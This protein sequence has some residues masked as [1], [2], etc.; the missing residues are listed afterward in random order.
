MEFYPGFE[1]PEKRKRTSPSVK[2]Y[3]LVYKIEDFEEPISK[4]ELLVLKKYLGEFTL[5]TNAGID[6]HSS[7]IKNGVWKGITLKRLK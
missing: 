5:T 4:Q 2:P 7:E 3:E 6:I 1:T